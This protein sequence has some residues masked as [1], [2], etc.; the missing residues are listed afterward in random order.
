MHYTPRLHKWETTLDGE[1]LDFS[2]Q[3]IFR[4]IIGPASG[5]IVGSGINN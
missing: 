3:R 2:I 1:M 4:G 5:K